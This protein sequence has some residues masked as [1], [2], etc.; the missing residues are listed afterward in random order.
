MRR[1][2]R[3]FGKL[4]LHPLVQMETDVLIRT[5]YKA[6]LNEG[7]KSK[8]NNYSLYKPKI[9][10]LYFY[11]TQTIKLCDSAVYICTCE[12]IQSA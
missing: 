3:G 4:Q 2:V 6:S 12:C 10:R 11:T 7:K 5:F 1:E 9:L 8:T